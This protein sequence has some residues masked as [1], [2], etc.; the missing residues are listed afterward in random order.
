MVGDSGSS[1]VGGGS[2]VA[3]IGGGG[4]GIAALAASWALVL[5]LEL[6]VSSCFF[7]MPFWGFVV[8]FAPPLLWVGGLVM[9]GNQ[10]HGSS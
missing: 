7:A 2:E 3:S 4:G 9:L 8:V 5:F 10:V 1:I 6:F